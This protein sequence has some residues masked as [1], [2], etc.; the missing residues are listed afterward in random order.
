MEV[1]S[2]REPGKGNL[3]SQARSGNS[4]GLFRKIL[5]RKIADPPIRPYAV[6]PAASLVLH[7]RVHRHVGWKLLASMEKFQFDDKK[8]GTD[9]ASDLLDKVHGGA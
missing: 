6:P 8:C 1:V 2:E 5:S 9:N 4:V 3:L 7:H